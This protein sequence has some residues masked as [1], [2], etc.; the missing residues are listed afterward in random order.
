M[1]EQ[2]PLL[3]IGGTM[4]FLFFSVGYACRKIRL[5]SVLAFIIIGIVL[6]GV[7]NGED[8]TL[9]SLAEIGI[10]LLFFLV[11]LEFPLRRMMEISKRVWPAGLLDIVLNL[12]VGLL[13]AL[14]FGLS[15]T[16]ALLIGAVL[17]LTDRWRR[18]GGR[19]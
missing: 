18:V 4:L 19:V 8:K 7:L 5:P 11:G 1:P 3:L 10:V 16:M 15:F 12:G 13:I 17:V 6:S 9:H 2:W 14:V